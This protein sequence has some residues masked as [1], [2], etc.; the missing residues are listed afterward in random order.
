MLRIERLQK[1]LQ[2]YMWLE[3]IDL[4]RWSGKKAIY[5]EPGK[6][7]WLPEEVPPLSK[8][9]LIAEPG[10]TLFLNQSV[11]I[12][13]EWHGKEFGILFSAEGEGL[14][15]IN[16][17]PYHGLDVNRSYIPLDAGPFRGEETMELDI[18]L[19]NPASR[20]GDA[21]NFRVIPSP[22][23]YLKESSIVLVN[24]PVQSL[25]YTVLVYGE[26]AK[27]LPEGNLHRHAIIA[28]LHRV[29][30]SIMNLSTEQLRDEGTVRSIEEK[31]H[32]ELA[33]LQ[34]SSI[35]A[36]MHMVGQSHIDVAWL[37]PLR[38]TVRKC[39]RTFSTV[40]TLMEHY[41][42][43]RFTH[44]QPQLLAYTKEH[45]PQLYAK[46]KEKIAEGRWELV[47]GMWVEP[48]LSIPSGESLV[49]QLLYGRQF[50]EGEF[51]VSPRIEWLPDTFGYCA[52]LPQLL[53][54]AGVDFFMT[55]KM[56]W[57]DTNRFPYSLFYWTGIDGTSIL[58]YLS[59][60]LNANFIPKHL[61]DYWSSFKQKSAH[62]EQMLLYGHGDG[63]GGVTREMIEYISRSNEL[64][65]L[66]KASFSTATAF[67]EGIERA[68][69][70]LPVWSGD[71][72]LEFHRGTYT[73]QA[74]TKW[75]NRKAEVLYRET[76]IWSSVAGLESSVLD[77]ENRLAE[78]WKLILLNQFHDIIPGT[79]IAEVYTK[80]AEQYEAVFS[81]G[82][83]S[84]QH[85]LAQ[86]AGNIASN[87]AG[88]PYVIFNSLSWERTDL[89][90]IR[91]GSEL[92]NLVA[93]E[94][95][96]RPLPTDIAPDEEGGYALYVALSNIPQIGYKTI[97]LREKDRN[98]NASAEETAAFAGKWETRFH[99]I[100]FDQ[101]T[102]FIS[103]WRD[104][105]AG[106]ELVK[107]GELANQLQ[108]FHD[109]SLVWDAW[110]I[111]T[112]FSMQPVDQIEL[113]SANVS[114]H[115]QTHDV[116][117]FRW[118][119]NQSVVEQRMVLYHHSP[120]I[121]FST[122]VDW[123]ESHKLLKVAFPVDILSSKATYEIP[124]GTVE[125]ATH[126]NTTWEQAQY[127]VC[128]HRWADLSEGE[129]GVSLLNDCKY[130]YDIKGNVMRL[131]LLRAPEYPDPGA[132]KGK[133]E[134]V[135][136][137]YPHSGDWR[138]AQVVRQGYELNHPLQVVPGD[139]SKGRG[140]RSTIASFVQLG[141]RHV[142]LDT[143][144]HSEDKQGIVLRLYESAGGRERVKL[145]FEWTPKHVQITN[146]LE[147]P[148]QSVEIDGNTVELDMLPYEVKTIKVIM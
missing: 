53:K 7:E 94:E 132:D 2:Q 126:T 105:A 84:K 73:S 136:S 66:P 49:R 142:V 121:D 16:G 114:F 36:M 48:D 125:R 116:L 129:Y 59:H 21:M 32:N 34:K 118:R 22:P 139:V 55:T 64:P 44:S 68:K 9:N 1:Y 70:E 27:L 67:F 79:S 96:G 89:V 120:R 104:K 39:S 101:S 42:E 40:C 76:E 91:G 81:I 47:G 122:A 54:K 58:S 95:D 111:D 106:R 33:E 127:E 63:G 31:L 102:G 123:K 87:D 3:Q 61:H 23:L 92:L 90:R 30:D 80:S 25:Y 62:A 146:L 108:L 145:S 100:E 134:L 45:Y 133:H 29:M 78:G 8:G 141:A 140:T 143:V 147:Q 50:Y 135:Y 12:P 138:T 119:V 38:E 60:G 28:A 109:R 128:G 86:L 20:P 35:P 77:G 65:G 131:S 72:Y 82:E 97:W 93:C 75:N 148:E 43:Y 74:K 112:R 83:E 11:S 37:W 24:R 52:S 113:E 124:F 137:V 26:A 46:I 5:I 57:N 6:Y 15:S 71:M 56:N 17:V 19:Y 13:A 41:P 4:L 144:K 98:H 110:D 85:A 115:G 130:G 10:I 103:K 51:G 117:C 18:E 69:P 88:R 107:P 14:L 99:A